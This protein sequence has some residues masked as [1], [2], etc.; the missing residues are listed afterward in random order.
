MRLWKRLHL[1][2]LHG[3]NLLGTPMASM[4]F[5]RS[6]TLPLF[7][8]PPS[9]YCRLHITTKT[10]LFHDIAEEVVAGA[11]LL[12]FG[13]QMNSV[14]QSSYC[15][16][17]DVLPLRWVALRTTSPGHHLKRHYWEWVIHT[18]LLLQLFLPLPFSQRDP[19]QQ[20]CATN[21]WEPGSL[22]LVKTL[23]ITWKNWVRCV[24]F[25]P[26]WRFEAVA[27]LFQDVFFWVLRNFQS[28]HFTLNFSTLKGR[29]K[30]AFLHCLSC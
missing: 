11:M 6:T 10:L 4:L 30:T 25:F 16:A 17:S 9:S 8:T 27:V 13:T 12:A 22:S 7:T 18:N 19:A 15:L 20:K 24:S 29:V 2:C 1:L 5:S 23:M 21:L 3:P 14:V 28:G 26:V